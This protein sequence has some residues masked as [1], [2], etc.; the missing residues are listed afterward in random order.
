M[1]TKRLLVL[2]SIFVLCASL[3]PVM[4]QA[5]RG[6]GRVTGAVTDA[7]GTP[8]EGVT[9]KFS[10]PKQKTETEVKSDKKGN[11]VMAGIRGG[12]WNVDFTK[13]GYKTV[14]ISTQIME[15]SYNEP[16][17]IKMEKAVSGPGSTVSGGEKPKGPDLAAAVAGRA[18]MDQKDYKGAIAK[19]QEALAANPNVYQIYGDVGTAYAQMGDY[20]NAIKAYQ[21]YMEKEK[22]AGVV[23][24]DPKPRIDL[25][26]IYLQK[27]DFEN[28][29]KI[30]AGVDES[31]ITDPT[32]FYNIGVSYYNT[33]DYDNA[34]KYFQKSVTVDPKFTDGYFQLGLTYV[35]KNDNAKAIENF[36][37]V[38]EIDPN[39]E[40]AKEAQEFINSI[41]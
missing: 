15:A 33:K 2:I 19:F 20:D 10:D 32:T 4:G 14:S 21:T 31:Q 40:S 7:Q 37:K 38:I 34:I 23:A 16:M 24:P 1:K 22:A 8:L 41:K 3:A 30:L 25:A 5:W 35:A 13:D 18:L 11:F 27:K 6:H 36:K 26:N 9:V 28:A 12:S 17:K 29:K 39:S